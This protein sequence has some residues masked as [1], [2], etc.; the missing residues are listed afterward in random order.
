MAASELPAD[1]DRMPPIVQ[2][3]PAAAAL[4]AYR[5]FTP[6]DGRFLS[7]E[8]AVRTILTQVA[9]DPLVAGQVVGRAHGEGLRLPAETVERIGYAFL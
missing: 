4:R 3:N 1:W 8:M 9:I 5:T 6:L 7:I 2:L